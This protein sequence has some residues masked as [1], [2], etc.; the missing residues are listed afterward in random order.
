MTK[1]Q[2]DSGGFEQPTAAHAD[3]AR[4]PDPPSDP[5]LQF[6][7]YGHLPSH[8][9]IVSKPFGELAENLVETLP[10]NTERTVALRKLLEAKDCAVRAVLMR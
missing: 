4:P 3:A 2:D 6:F 1:T 10:R 5:L 9:A 7:E 8:L